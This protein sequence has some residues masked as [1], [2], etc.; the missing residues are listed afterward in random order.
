VETNRWAL[1]AFRV[2]AGL[3]QR[4]LAEKLGVAH[5]TIMRLEN[6]QRG[7][8]PKMGRKI[9]DFF[10]VPLETIFFIHYDAS[11]QI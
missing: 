7:A 9:A 8:S 2:K 1:Q 10:G 5:T 11:G 4:E 3:S 6:G